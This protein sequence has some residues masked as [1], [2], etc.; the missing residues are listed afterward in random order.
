MRCVLDL[1]SLSLGL[2]QGFIVRHLK[3]IC[4]D[5]L[6]KQARDLVVGYAA[7]LDRVVMY[8]GHKNVEVIDSADIGDKVRDFQR[9]IDVWFSAFTF[10]L[11]SGV[12]PC[13]KASGM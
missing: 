4:G 8:R 7:I 5:L 12:A 6:A 3:H 1:Q 2:W 11:L 9:V 13:G 10:P